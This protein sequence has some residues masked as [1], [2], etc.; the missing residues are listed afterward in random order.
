[1]THKFLSRVVNSYA[2]PCTLCTVSPL[3]P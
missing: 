3:N 1:M 2:V